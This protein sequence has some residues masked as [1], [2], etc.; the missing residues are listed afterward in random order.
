MN[1]KKK[2]KDICLNAENVASEVLRCK[3]AQEEL[4]VEEIREL[5]HYTGD[6]EYV[7]VSD[8]GAILPLENKERD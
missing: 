6:D 7:Y 5:L 1:Y 4:T 3:E 2:W 8:N